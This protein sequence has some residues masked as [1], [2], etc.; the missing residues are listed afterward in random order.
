MT[1]HT[2]RELARTRRQLA[3]LEKTVA[4]ERDLAL[5]ALPSDYGFESVA[6]FA[7]AVTQA[8]ATRGLRTGKVR[9]RRRRRAKPVPVEVTPAVVP[10][11]EPLASLPAVVEAMT[12]APS[13]ESAG[14]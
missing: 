12:P 7:A 2:L 14:G 6:D 4:R 13:T 9:A 3:E 10:A 1:P 8:C 11:P 5:A